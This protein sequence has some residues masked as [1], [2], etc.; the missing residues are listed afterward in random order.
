[1]NQ[2]THAI[3]QQTQQLLSSSPNRDWDED[4]AEEQE[5][6]ENN[7]EAEAEAEVQKQKQ[8]LRDSDNPDDPEQ[9]QVASEDID[10]PPPSN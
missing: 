6:T 10:R 5:A 9:F 1:L 3:L 8:R 2:E 4:G 7:A